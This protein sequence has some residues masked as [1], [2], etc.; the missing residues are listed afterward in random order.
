MNFYLSCPLFAFCFAS[1]SLVTPRRSYLITVTTDAEVDTS[2]P[3]ED[4][5]LP[6][7]S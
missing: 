2:R 5:L 4:E 6:P 7:S 1:F 3:V